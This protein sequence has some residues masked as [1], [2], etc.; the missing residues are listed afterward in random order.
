MVE[1]AEDPYGHGIGSRQFPVDGEGLGIAAH[2][3]GRGETQGLEGQQALANPRFTLRRDGRR[4]LRFHQGHGVFQQ[5]ARGV[6]LGV[7]QDLAAGGV[8]RGVRDPCCL[9]GGGVDPQGVAIHPAQHR[10]PS[11]GGG[12][13]VGGP[14]ENLGGP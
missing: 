14:G 13:Q 10:W 3:A 2:V 5:D 4:D 6:A 7:P 12:I 8:G 1:V 9:E 11:A